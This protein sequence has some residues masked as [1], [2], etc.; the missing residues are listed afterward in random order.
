MDMKYLPNQ[1][2]DDRYNIC[3]PLHTRLRNEWTDFSKETSKKLTEAVR[4]AFIV[5]NAPVYDKKRIRAL[6]NKRYGV[7]CVPEALES[8]GK[9][10]GLHVARV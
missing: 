6:R 3:V 5:D 1:T 9:W 4:N 2:A 10:H 8:Q 7:F